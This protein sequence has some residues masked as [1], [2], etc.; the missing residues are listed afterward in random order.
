MEV[1]PCLVTRGDVELDRILD[2]FPKHWAEPIVWDNSTRPRDLGVYGRY[3]AIAESETAVVYVQDDDCVLAP[4]AFELLE[5]YYD[6]GVLTANMP[7]PFRAHYSD[8]C[9][10]GFGAIF[11]RHLP[12]HAFGRLTNAV[13]IERMIR[14]KS[15]DQ[16]LRTC[17]VYFTALT[18]MTWLSLPYENLPWATSDTRMYRQKT[19]VG[20][21]AK[22]LEHARS[23]R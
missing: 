17:D 2:S 1:T 12:D 22:A 4:E 15:Q 14:K 6:I 23:L 9:L 19:H 8:S 5:R 3:A 16:F 20:E 7:T 10:V 21:R 11:D 18:P 13:G